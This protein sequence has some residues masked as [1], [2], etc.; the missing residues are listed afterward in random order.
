MTLVLMTLVLMTLV[1]MTL[2]LITFYLSSALLSV[3]ALSSLIRSRLVQIPFDQLSLDVKPG[4]RFANKVIDKKVVFTDLSLKAKNQ[5]QNKKMILTKT[6]Y[7]SF[8]F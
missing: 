5:L 8:K 3:L 4:R 7:T 2:V 6:G 1:L